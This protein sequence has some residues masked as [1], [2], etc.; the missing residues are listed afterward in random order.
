MALP[1]LKLID[2]TG[3]LEFPAAVVLLQVLQATGGGQRF[4]MGRV[5]M[6]PN[7]ELERNLFSFA[8][9]AVRRFENPDQFRL[10]V[11]D[12]DGRDL[13]E[14]IIEATD[15]KSDKDEL[16]IKMFVNGIIGGPF[17]ELGY[18]VIAG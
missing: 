13:A 8:D 7:A 16:F 1:L 6:T 10:V 9:D 18:K 17:Y 3:P 12:D 2:L 4:R 15:I 11:Q 14:T 5:P